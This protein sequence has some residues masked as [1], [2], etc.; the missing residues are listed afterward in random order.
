M[1]VTGKYSHALSSSDVELSMGVRDVS[2]GTS[3]GG[4]CTV[5]KNGSLKPII[6]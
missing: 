1:E 2:L 6:V 5:A 4:Q 3:S